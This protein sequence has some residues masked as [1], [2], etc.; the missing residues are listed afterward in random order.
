MNSTQLKEYAQLAQAAY[1]YFEKSSFSWFG[2]TAAGLTRDLI[3]VDT[4]QFTNEE[5][6]AFTTRFELLH[7][8]TDTPDDNGFS[9][10]LFKDRASG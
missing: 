7:Q 6:K 10:C 9:A 8:S 3:S 1:A 4:S 2:G 5:A